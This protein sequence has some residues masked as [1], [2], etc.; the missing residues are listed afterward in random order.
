[1]KEYF[2]TFNNTFN[3]ILLAPN[4][5]KNKLLF[6]FVTLL[7]KYL[8]LAELCRNVVMLRGVRR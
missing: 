8:L 6:S 2:V 3:F 5:V 1:M 4:T 7:I